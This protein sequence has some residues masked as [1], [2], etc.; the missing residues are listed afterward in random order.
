MP[1]YDLVITP[2]TAKTHF[3]SFLEMKQIIFYDTIEQFNEWCPDDNN[4]IALVANGDIIQI[5]IDV[6]ERALI[7]LIN[8]NVD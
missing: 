6:F 3:A 1:K 4:F 2:D 8:Y 7:L 5:A